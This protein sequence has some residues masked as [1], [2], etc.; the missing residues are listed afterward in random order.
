MNITLKWTAFADTVAD[1]YKLYKAITGF[2]IPFPNSLII[3]NQF[4]FA[5]TSPDRQVVTLTG[6]SI[7]QVAANLNAA[8]GIQATPNQAGTALLVRC[9]ARD[10]PKLKLYACTALTSLGMVPS[11]IG[12]KENF[13]L[14]T[15]IP[16]VSGTFEYSY[17]DVDGNALDYYHLTTVD[18]STESLPTQDLQ[19]V[20]TPESV[21]IIEGRIIDSQNNPIVGAEVKAQIQVPVGVSDNSG[22]RTG[23][24]TVITDSL[25]R[26][27]IPILQG[28][29]VLFQIEAIGYNNVVAVPA[30]PFVLFKDLIPVDDHVFGDTNQ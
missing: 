9:T 15:T 2:S 12:P 22:I 1:S 18:G 4:I 20:L 11:L 7:S 24:K 30:T 29:L 10:N 23:V 3:G 17:I 26:W 28:Q 5:A 13:Q 8:K 21:C 6:T 19:P 16:F 14:L 25:G 27:S